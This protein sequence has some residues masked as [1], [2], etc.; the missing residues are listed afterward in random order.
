M[1]HHRADCRRAF[2]RYDPTC[3]RCRELAAGAPPRAGWCMPRD[4]Q[5]RRHA[6]DVA[7]HVASERHRTGACGPVCT[8]GDW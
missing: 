7:A 3:A 1:T 6:A 5:D 2:R 4:A 8:F